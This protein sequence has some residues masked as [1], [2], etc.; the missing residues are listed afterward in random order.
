MTR[1]MRFALLALGLA[2][3]SAGGCAVDDSDVESSETNLSETLTLRFVSTDGTLSLKSSGK[4]LAC[5]ER[6]EGLSGERVTC[7][8]TGEKV[9]VIVK[10]TG[11]S[12][13][14]VRD[15]DQQR[16]Y[17]NCSPSGDVEGLPALMSCKA[18]P[19]HPR[20]TGGLSSPF[21]SSVPGLSVPNS[22]W[23]DASEAVLRGMEPR[24]PAQFDELRAKGIEKV[25][26]FKNATGADDVGKETTAWAMPAG[27]VLHVPFRWTNIG[28]FQKPCEQTLDA[29]RFIH[30]SQEA[31][32][33][34]FFH[35]TVGE[36]RTGY[37]AALYAQ[38]FE[39]VDARSAFEDDMCEHGYSSGNP[40]K[41]AF[42]VGKL[43][44]ELTPL[45]R[46]MAYLVST[47]ALTAELDAAICATEPTVPD[48][49]MSEPM[50][51][52]VSTTLVP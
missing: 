17:Y 6:F 27:D 31:G 18:T 14:A 44:D 36:D 39:G 5:S 28:G 20:G 23:V 33:K 47:R 13:V 19:L 4:V 49:F 10:S 3:F 26:I 35:C 52:G 1:G 50:I 11:T 8:R 2:F 51:C 12:V 21:D 24:T 9:Q 38:L 42:V 7:Q 30:A 46:S 25:L 15:M 48:D 29:L 41:P 43:E 34:V 37:L 40:Q 32:K 22:H 16:G 45:Y